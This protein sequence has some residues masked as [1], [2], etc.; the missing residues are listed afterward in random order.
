MVASMEYRLARQLLPPKRI[1]CLLRR[2][3]SS[4][5]EQNFNNN[6]SNNNNTHY[7]LEKK[8]TYYNQEL[9]D[10]EAAKHLRKFFPEDVL[11]NL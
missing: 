7:G 9:I 1:T 5:Y 4:I 10:R 6:N 2:F 3:E 11:S 8:W